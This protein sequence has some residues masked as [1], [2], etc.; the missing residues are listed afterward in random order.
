MDNNLGD[1]S[2]FNSSNFNKIGLF[3]QPRAKEVITF[4]CQSR[5]F[6]KVFFKLYDYDCDYDSLFSHKMLLIL[7]RVREI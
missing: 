1:S 5:N 7:E 4:R 3:C 6:L 2:F